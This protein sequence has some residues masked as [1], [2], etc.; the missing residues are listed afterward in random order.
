MPQI[1]SYAGVDDV[2]PVVGTSFYIESSTAPVFVELLDADETPIEVG[3][4]LSEGQQLGGN[5][6]SKRFQSVRIMNTGNADVVIEYYAGSLGFIDRRFGFDLNGVMKIVSAGATGY[7]GDVVAMT[8]S[9]AIKVLSE[10]NNRVSATF[11][12]ETDGKF[13]HD[14][15]VTLSA[16]IKYTAGDVRE[17]K[18]TA[19]LW[20]CPALSVDSYVLED[21]I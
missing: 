7:D 12:S 11:Y 20:F 10:K 3:R 13:W 16:G 8:A 14:N 18:N 19:E 6:N 5:F 15:T 1:T 2:F 21:L 17:I 4:L 9:V